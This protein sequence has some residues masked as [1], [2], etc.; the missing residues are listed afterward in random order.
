MKSISRKHPVA[1]WLAVIFTFLISAQI[2]PSQ[3]NAFAETK[4]SDSDDSWQVIF[5][6]GQRIGYART[7]TRTV[8]KDGKAIV[9][10]LN[11]THMTFK[12]F[13]Q[14]LKV[15]M[16]LRTE[17]NQDGE[18]LRFVSETKNPPADTVKT[19]GTVQQ[20]RLYLE[21][22]IA[23]RSQ[24]TSIPW[25]RDVKAPG[26]EDRL[27]RN[28]PLKPGDKRKFKS[29][30]P[31]LNK[32]TDVSIVA[33]DMRRVK[34]FD[35]TT[36]EALQ[37][38]ITQSLL[39]KMI[40]RTYLDENGN[41]LKT[42]T[43]ILGTTM[44]TYSV[45]KEVAL[46]AIAGQ[47][48]D[49]AVS[50]LVRLDKPIRNAHDAQKI[51]YR[52]TVPE[53]NPLDYLLKGPTQS[54]TRV[55]DDTAELTVTR[56]RPDPNARQVRGKPE[57]MG[58]TRFLQSRDHRVVEH[59]RRA[60]AGQTNPTQIA[61]SMEKYVNKNLKSKN[62]STALASAAE[63]ARDMQ[64]D[65]TEHAVLLAAMLRTKKIP[66]RIAVGLVYSELHAAFAGHMWT[67]AFLGG[68]WLP[69]DA[70]MGRGG[71]GPGHIKLAESS[72]ADDAPTPLVTMLPLLDILGKMKIEVVKVE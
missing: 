24:K 43:P 33:V 22:V 21:I 68:K 4:P 45:S 6:G 12:R 59:A 69:L 53:L 46:E 56:L 39:P 58:P 38:R 2:C 36:R 65:C 55:D 70:T 30:I 29:F 17:E 25:D 63:V 35:G 66:S 10:T 57:Y 42:E 28:P 13:G 19:I 41:T 1:A 50:T 48:L 37:A 23:G 27:L 31:E 54:A 49:I 9:V 26:Y 72:F 44:V 20:N 3:A 40:Q 15:Q 51:V 60:T 71:I 52:I 18:M 67:E 61:L 11:E 34:L 5:I 64:G 32:I 16:N 47:E 14:E 62:F 7:T 8:K